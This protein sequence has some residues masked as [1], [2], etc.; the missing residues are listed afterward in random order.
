MDGVEVGAGTGA[1]GRLSVFA[2]RGVVE[3]FY[4][5]PWAHED[6]LWLLERM[7]RWGMNTYV[8]APKDDPLHLAR[9]REPYPDTQLAE[10]RALIVA[11]ERAGVRV[12]FAVSPGRSIVYSDRAERAALV[13]KLGRS[14]PSARQLARRRRR[15]SNLHFADRS[16]FRSVADAQLALLR[17]MDVRR[18]GLASPTDTWVEPTDYLRGAPR[19]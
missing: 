19:A 7:G 12:G 16:A 3:G 8:Y 9:W 17:E 5:K 15:A 14:T 10:F 4:G 11:G 18:D 1:G 13:S 6:R 2:I